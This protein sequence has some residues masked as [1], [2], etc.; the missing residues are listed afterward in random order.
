MEAI[1][2]HPTA[3]LHTEPSPGHTDVS[4][5]PA[6]AQKGRGESTIII[7]YLLTPTP[8]PQVN[9]LFSQP[10]NKAIQI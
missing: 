5:T 7:L 1:L 9:G 2:F 8:G 10:K 6:C 3:W 4:L